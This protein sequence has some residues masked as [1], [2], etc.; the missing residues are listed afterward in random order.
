MTLY[1]GSSRFGSDLDR[2][3][4]FYPVAAEGVLEADGP[5]GWRLRTTREYRGPGASSYRIGLASDCSIAPNEMKDLIGK[6]VFLL[7][8]GGPERY[9]A[10]RCVNLLGS[11]VTSAIRDRYVESCMA[12]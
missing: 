8:S 6:P 11:D 4:H 2:I 10:G 7:L 12:R 5:Y 3:V 1:P 9:E